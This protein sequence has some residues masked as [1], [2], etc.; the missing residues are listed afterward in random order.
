[1][2]CFRK[3]L[4]QLDIVFDIF[5]LLVQWSWLAPRPKFNE[6]MNGHSM[7]AIRVLAMT[8]DWVRH[9]RPSSASNYQDYTCQPVN[10]HGYIQ[11]YWYTRAGAPLLCLVTAVE[12]L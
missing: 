11:Q 2:L 6:C 4:E 3:C 9:K 8:V 5:T 7:S 10:I 1:M 12:D